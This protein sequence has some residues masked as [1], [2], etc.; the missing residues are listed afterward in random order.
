M[1]D[2]IGLMKEIIPDVFI[3]NISAGIKVTSSRIANPVI[4]PMNPVLDV[5]KLITKEGVTVWNEQLKP[6][7]VPFDYICDLPGHTFIKFKA[8]GNVFN[9]PHGCPEDHKIHKSTVF[10]ES[11]SVPPPPP[12]KGNVCFF[13]CYNRK[14]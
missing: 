11:F 12:P 9:I 6:R 13:N 3:Y 14:T 5:N 7:F 8:K 2:K 10:K 1:C 4:I